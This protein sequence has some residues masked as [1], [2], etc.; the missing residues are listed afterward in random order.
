MCAGVCEV[1]GYTDGKEMALVWYDL[2]TCS[3]F[4]SHEEKR[5]TPQDS[6]G[7]GGNMRWPGGEASTHTG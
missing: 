3:A 1:C 5:P 2:E 6:F 4:S 7:S